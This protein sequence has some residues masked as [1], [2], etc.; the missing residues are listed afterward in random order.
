MADYGKY[1]GMAFQIAD[2]VFDLKGDVEV[3]GK[4]IGDDL[5]EGKMTLPVIFARDNADPKDKQ[6]LQQAFESKSSEKFDQV[7]E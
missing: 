1:L 5:V 6:L 3:T 2:D 7:L 4:N